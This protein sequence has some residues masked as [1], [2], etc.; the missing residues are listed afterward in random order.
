[1]TRLLDTY[2]MEPACGRTSGVRAPFERVSRSEFCGSLRG[3]GAIAQRKGNSG[4]IAAWAASAPAGQ[5][6]VVTLAELRKLDR[7]VVPV[8]LDDVLP[9]AA[10]VE[11][12]RYPAAEKVVLLFVM[13]RDTR[14]T[15][16]DAVRR[17]AFEL[18]S[19]SSIGPEGSL[20]QAGLIPLP[21]AERVAARSRAIAFVE[22]P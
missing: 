17:A 18:L 10:N 9:T 21:P 5:L 3:D 2:V 6:A 13:P 22:H 4:E 8:P 11:S 20:A 12:G 14:P 19:E 15:Q 16:R 1:A 7:F